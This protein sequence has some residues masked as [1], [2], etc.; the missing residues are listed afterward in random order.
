MAAAG[1]VLVLVALGVATAR[2]VALWKDTRTLFTHARRL[3]GESLVA[4]EMLGIADVLQGRTPEGLALL[5]RGV[6]LAP[7]DPRARL[8]LATALLTLPGHEA[9]AAAHLRLAVRIRPASGEAMNALAW[10]LATSPDPSVR[11]GREAERL[12]GRAVQVSGGGDPSLLDT[13]AAAQAAAGRP[14]AAAATARRALG[15]AERAR[16]DPLAAA[17]RGRLASY[18]RGRAWVDSARAAGMP[19]GH[20]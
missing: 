13:Q 12:A 2:Q 20:P 18:E 6:A 9:E 5:R 19:P 16:A 1:A 14:A 15:L 7:A 4:D 8:N 3:T 10:L 17:I 11:D